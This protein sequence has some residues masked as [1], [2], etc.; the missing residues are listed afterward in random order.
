MNLKIKVCGLTKPDQILELIALEIDFLGFIFYKKSPRYALNT[1][2]LDQ[3]S[4][5]DHQG[6]V[7]VFVNEKINDIIEIAEKAGLS[8]VQLH[9]DETDGF[10]SELKKELDPEIKLIKV[11][12]IGNTSENVKSKIQNLKSKVDYFLFDTDSSSFGGTGLSF[13]WNLLNDT[14]FTKPYFLSGGI[15]EES[16]ANISGLK[17]LPFALDINSKFETE[18]GNKDLPKIKKFRKT[19][20]EL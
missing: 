3:I 17:K 1:L 5:F 16:L 19:L 12:R 2:T 18:P 6:K 11:F 20:N 10:I 9:G 8:F 4:T 7:G 14:E 13:D 15:S